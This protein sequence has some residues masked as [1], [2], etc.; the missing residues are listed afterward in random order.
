[1]APHLTTRFARLAITTGASTGPLV[2]PDSVPRLAITTVRL[3][4]AAE[5][6]ANAA[7]SA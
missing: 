6:L 2:R 3:A 1:M 4:I 7:D 5:W